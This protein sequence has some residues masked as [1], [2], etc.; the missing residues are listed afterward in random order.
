MMQWLG[1]IVAALGVWALWL[2]AR[3]IARQRAEL[4]EEKEVVYAF[5]HDLSEAFADIAAAGP[6]TDYLL[7]RILFH[8][9]QTAKAR[10]GAIYFTEPDGDTLRARAVAG[11]FP[12]LADPGRAPDPA[13][14]GFSERLEQAVRDAPVRLGV[15]LIGAVAADGR[16]LLIEDAELDPRVPQ[17][18][19][20]FLAV[21]TLLLVP[22]RFQ[23][24]VLGVLALANR[25]DDAP[26]LQ[27]DL[28]LLQALADQAS[29]AVYFAN[30]NEELDKKRI[31]DQDLSVARRIQTA[32]LPAR[33]PTAPHLEVAAFSVPAR[34]IGGDYYDF[35]TID[36][37][38]LGLAIADVSGK[39]VSGAMLMSICRSVFRAHAADGLSPVAVLKAINRILSADI[40]ED[41]FISMAYCILDTRAFDITLACAGHP[42]PLWIA[43]HGRVV[44]V[45]AGGVA[46]GLLPDDAFDRQIEEITVHLE[47]GD[48]WALY[49]DGVTEAARPGG[50]EWGLD[51]LRQAVL[52]ARPRAASSIV[53]H[54][55]R[56]LL[57]FAGD[58]AQYDDM[59]LVVVR[60][61]E[62]ASSPA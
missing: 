10:A 13:G 14:T 48:L 6:Q 46:I 52:T 59:T 25:I 58:V 21:Q 49:T 61:Q 50:K 60:R 34:E 31:L 24:S 3:H 30:V 40:Y 32:L 9:Q 39:G 15:G 57:A 12:P 18:S 51:N 20:E 4:L 19:H 53:A 11:L 17:F 55:R 22:M 47:P 44:P 7:Q 16:S 26:F 2:R 36:P 23:N 28:N 8:A 62:G 35:V 37:H 38:H 27:S 33:L 1:W 45:Q 41:M 42:R 29:V 56:E 5:I 54:V 43:A